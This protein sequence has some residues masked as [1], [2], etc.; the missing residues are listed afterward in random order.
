MPTPLG[1]FAP[2]RR[3]RP[4]LHP[5]EVVFDCKACQHRLPAT[6]PKRTHRDEPQTSADLP[7][8]GPNPRGKAT[9]VSKNRSYDHPSHMGKPQ[10][11]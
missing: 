4:R 7:T 9:G 8:S 6:V 5:K 1:P 2:K 11:I 3:G 10:R